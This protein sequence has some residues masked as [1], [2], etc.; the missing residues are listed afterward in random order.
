MVRKS[1]SRLLDE[2]AKKFVQ[3]VLKGMGTSPVLK[4]KPGKKK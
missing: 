3:G 2:T 4:K 1:W